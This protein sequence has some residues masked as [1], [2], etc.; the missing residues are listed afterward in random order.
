[1]WWTLRE[2]RCTVD[3]SSSAVLPTYTFSKQ[4]DFHSK[5]NQCPLTSYMTAT[6]K[7]INRKR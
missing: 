6:K 7:M 5:I 1:M 4:F 3:F 2:F